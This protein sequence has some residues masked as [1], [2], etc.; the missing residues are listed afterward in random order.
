M[1][2]VEICA[3]PAASLHVS[4]CIC[5]YVSLLGGERGDHIVLLRVFHHKSLISLERGEEKKEIRRKINIR[6]RRG[7]GKEAGIKQR[8]EVPRKCERLQREAQQQIKEA[9]LRKLEKDR[10]GGGVVW[11]GYNK[12]KSPNFKALVMIK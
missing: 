7:G 8:K 11:V 1:T 2:R 10:R 9:K 6:T 12:Y 3:C 5:A 4:G